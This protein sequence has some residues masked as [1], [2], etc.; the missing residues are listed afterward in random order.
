LRR[1]SVPIE[2]LQS[3]PGNARRG[4]LSVI[5]ESLRVH[6]QFRDI[7]VQEST[8][9]ILAGNHT[10]MAAK[11]EGLT[12]IACTFVDVDD[13]QAKKIV[14]VDNRSN[15]VAGYDVPSLAE[16][17]RDLDTLEGTGFDDQALNDVM[18][19]LGAVGFKAGKDADDAPPLPESEP[20]TQH[21]DLYQL[22]NHRLLCGD[23]TSISDVERLLGDGQVHLLFTDPPYNMNFDGRSGKWLASDNKRPQ[24][25]LINDN[26][27]TESFDDL[28]R[29]SLTNAYSVL[30]DGGSAYCF[31]DWRHYPQVS[32]IFSSIFNQKSAI[33]WDK[34]HFGMGV[35]YRMQYEL[36]IFGCKGEKPGIWTAGK[37]E[38]DVW[39][40]QRE[41]VRQYRHVTQK[42][43]EIAERAIKNS[44]NK[45][46]TVLDLFCGSGTTLVA[47]EGL[48]R[49]CL[50]MELDRGYCDVIVARW[51]NVTEKKAVLL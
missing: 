43:I 41:N 2:E 49:H 30:E 22:G 16:L 18:N 10:W 8:G 14:L 24:K 38:R 50:A 1:A 13:R 34:T 19:A 32:E 17:L 36:L 46:E 7:V 42:P 12:E 20:R 4:D 48:G 37:T 40:L 51:E 28:I 29:G 45:G 5:R 3:Y 9:F 15:D 44:S 33:V 39:S 25:V 35:H 26:L 6:G 31:C 47:A 27:S 23:A 11:E 21:G